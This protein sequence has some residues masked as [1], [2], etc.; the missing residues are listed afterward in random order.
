M[1]LKRIWILGIIDG[2]F[3]FQKNAL[4]ELKAGSQFKEHYFFEPTMHI[5]LGD[6]IIV[7]R[8]LLCYYL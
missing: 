4:K 3:P 6:Y 8:N 5:G 7:Q 1:N 2:N